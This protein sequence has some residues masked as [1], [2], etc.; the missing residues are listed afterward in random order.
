MNADKTAVEALLIDTL[1]TPVW[2][3]I[4]ILFLLIPVT[5][6]LLFKIP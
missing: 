5:F 1:K 6:P 3:P 4:Q 2:T